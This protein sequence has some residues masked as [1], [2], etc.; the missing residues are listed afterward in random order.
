MAIITFWA[1]YAQVVD[2]Y[3]PNGQYLLAG[4]AILAMLLMAFVFVGAF[5]KWYRLLAIPAT[6]TDQN[7]EM[8][9]EVVS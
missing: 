8:V 2:S 1:G 6:K 5:R 3:L 4:L 7:G 9:K